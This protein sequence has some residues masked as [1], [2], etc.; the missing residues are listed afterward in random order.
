MFLSRIITVFFRVGS[1]Q[2]RICLVILF[3]AI[4]IRAFTQVPSYVPK[5][6]L[7]GWWPFSG[8]ANDQSGNGNNGISSG[9]IL[10]ADRFGN[11]NMAYFFDGLND[12][13]KLSLQ[14]KN[15]TAY[16]ISAWFKTSIGG[17]ILSGRGLP[18]QVGL[19][20]HIH[21]FPTG[22]PL[23][24]GRAMFVADASVISVGKL[25]YPTYND[26]KWHHIVG[27]YNGV[28]GQVKPSQFS[29]YIDGTLVSQTYDSQT[30]SAT[31]P[32]SNS[33]N[34]LI[35][36]HQ[37]WPGG[38]IFTG[39]LDDFGIW[40]RSLTPSE[41]QQLYEAGDIRLFVSDQTVSCG[42]YV[43]VPVN[44]SSF[45]NLMSMQGTIG[46][47]PSVI[48][49]DSISGFGPSALSMQASN[50]G[51]T[52]VSG[53]KLFFSWNDPSLKGV[54]LPDSS[55]IFR[56]R[57]TP[58]TNAPGSTNITVSNS[59]VTVELVDTGYKKLPVTL[60][61][62]K[63]SFDRRLPG[64]NPL[65]DTTRGC[66]SVIE[67]DAG[68]GFLQYIWSNGASGRTTRVSTNGR[69]T[70]RAVN[71]EGCFG[72]DTT[73]VSIVTANILQGDTSVC[74]FTSLNLQAQAGRDW[75]YRWTPT[76]QQGSSINIRP[77]SS[78]T[79]RLT[80]SEGV[81]QCT[82]SVIVR[83]FS[84]DTSLLVRGPLEFCAS[85]DTLLRLQ[86]VAGNSYQWLRNAVA[87]TGATTSIYNP[88]LSG[89]YR[90][91]VR[92]GIGCSDSSR[93]VSVVVRPLPVAG[94]S[95]PG[96]GLI[97]EGTTRLLQAS[98]GK[99]Y[100]WYRNDTLLMSRISDTLL[101]SS[102]GRYSLEAV[103]DFGCSRRADTVLRFE[104]VPRVKPY[105]SIL[106]QCADVAV[107]FTNLSAIPPAGIP[108]WRW[109]FGDGDSSRQFS[110]EHIYRMPGE[111]RVSLIYGNSQCTGHADTVY[112]TLRLIRESSIRFA[113]QVVVKDK[114]KTV[115][116]RDTATAWN[117]LPPTGLD[118]PKRYN[119]RVTIRQNQQYLI[120]TRL[121]NGCVVMDSLLVKVADKS[122]IFVP[123][124]FSPNRDGSN[125]RLFPILVGIADLKYFRVFNR[126]GN[127]V[128]E[129]R[130]MV[131]NTGWDGT[132]RG[133]PQPMDTYSW[134][135]E[136]IDT[137][138]KTLKGF[139]NTMI[140]R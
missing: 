110:T 107:K 76:G 39:K 25:T 105:F 65:K 48:R 89:S 113:D 4:S 68:S 2:T 126:W 46:W 130:A 131:S 44:L 59:P 94:L 114:P 79:Y 49:F 24:I 16:S 118:N 139:G 60:V 99:N 92:N 21:N 74:K 26:N 137:D 43:D 37:V 84:V 14:Q 8:N 13:I 62:G 70:V 17:P 106:G 104:Q 117:W 35:G 72:E 31:A 134:T 33:T 93:T 1:G 54:S 23:Q 97:C 86:A 78:T 56:L 11:L 53:G 136:A 124:A 91:A 85:G 128:Y 63:I 9:A 71:A 29:I 75:T 80:V 32:I 120:E 64:F 40:N 82:D 88:I 125:D 18:N 127:I 19:T 52:Q 58:L 42:T 138:G 95:S 36:A 38:G 10:D 83:I 22:G 55:A 6:G 69:Y 109:D 7:L 133:V 34:L 96:D 51:L 135:A 122:G 61:N 3:A 116:G 112:Q 129:S 27:V 90:V 73:V 102:A 28:S 111:Y 103:N 132:Y 47:D 66:G 140:I 30:G 41:V 20:L 108:A 45:K 67:L 119:P 81:T 87:L 101:I 123:K 98:G 15:I 115:F 5:D 57:F 50:F 77:D 121:R 100:R 12:S